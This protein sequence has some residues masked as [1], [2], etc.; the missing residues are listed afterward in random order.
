MK[1]KGKSEVRWTEN[2]G[3]TTVTYHSKQKY[4]SIKQPL[5]PER[6]GNNILS[7]GSNVFPFSFQ[8]PAQDL[9]SSFQGEFGKILYTLEANLSRSLRIDSKARAELTLVSKND[10]NFDSSLRVPQQGATEKKMNLFS[11]GYVAMNVNM[12]KTGFHQG[13]G[14]KIVASIHNKSSRD[15]RPKYCVYRKH[16]F[17]AKGKRKVA[18][19][20]VLKEVGEA[21]PPSAGQTVTKVITIPAT[22][23]PTIS[24]C[25]NIKVEYRLK[26]YLDIKYAFDPTIKFPIVILPFAQSSDEE[27]PPVGLTYGFDSFSTVPAAD[28]PPTYSAISPSAPPPPSY[29]THGAYGMYPSL[30]GYGSKS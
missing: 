26:V 21:V 14:V 1:L 25:N 27:K 30:P 3:K 11:S 2:H 9:P 7:M 23:T 22:T 8:I 12:D 13:E 17:F 4:F 6:Q 18:T 5:I 19:K 29:D 10:P 16:S 24:N 20:D 28:Y 15:V